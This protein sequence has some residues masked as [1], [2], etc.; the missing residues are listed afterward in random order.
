MKRATSEV[1]QSNEFKVTLI[2]SFSLE[3]SAVLDLIGMY[4]EINQRI[5]DEGLDLE[6]VS[7][8][9]RR[10]TALLF[11]LKSIL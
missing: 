2:I 11:S 9:F 6:G 1:N 7:G 5:I 3:M 4:S 8:H 10:A